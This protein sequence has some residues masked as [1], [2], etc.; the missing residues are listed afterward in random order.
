VKPGNLTGASGN[1]VMRYVGNGSANNLTFNNVVA[2]RD[3]TYSMRVYYVCGAGARNATVV[4]NGGGGRTYSFPGT[5]NWSTVGSATIN[6]DLVAG[7]NTIRFGYSS[8][9]APDF[10]RIVVSS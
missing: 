10:D 1:V 2:P 3:G 4:I 5:A 8:A 6:V 9:P 7:A